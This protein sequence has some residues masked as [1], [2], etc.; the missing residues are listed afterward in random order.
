MGKR[1]LGAYFSGGEKNV[2]TGSK[3]KTPTGEPRLNIQASFY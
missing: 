2:E 1:T 3:A